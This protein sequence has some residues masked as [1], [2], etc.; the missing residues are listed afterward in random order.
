V[1]GRLS[2]RA[3]RH[4]LFLLLPNA[5]LGGAARVHAS[6]VEAV[7]DARPLVVFT[8]PSRNA[9]FASLFRNRAGLWDVSRWPLYSLAGHST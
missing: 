6:I 4:T 9:A 7:A 8:T 5:D 3:H 2:P 1:A